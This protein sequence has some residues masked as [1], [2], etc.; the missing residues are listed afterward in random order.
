MLAGDLICTDPARG[1]GGAWVDS[2]VIIQYWVR[3]MDLVV[4]PVACQVLS[5][6]PFSKKAKKYSRKKKLTKSRFL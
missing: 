4:V 1:L 6:M 5:F 3:Y 2:E